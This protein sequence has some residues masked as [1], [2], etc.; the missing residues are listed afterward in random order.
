MNPDDARHALVRYLL[1]RSARPRNARRGAHLTGRLRGAADTHKD[2]E[3]AVADT[4]GEE[5]IFKTFDEAAVFAAGMALRSGVPIEI[6]VL[7]F[8]RDGAVWWGSVDGGD[9]YDGDPEA[10]VFDRLVLKIASQGRVP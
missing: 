3:F 7:V 5:H 1:E 6:D 2:V 9:D 8:S 4:R 10:S